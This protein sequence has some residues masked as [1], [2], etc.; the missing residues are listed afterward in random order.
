[1]IRNPSIDT[2]PPQKNNKEFGSTPVM[3]AS[4]TRLAEEANN[5]GELQLVTHLQET[6]SSSIDAP[7]VTDS[8][9]VEAGFRPLSTTETLFVGFTAFLLYQIRAK[10]RIGKRALKYVTKW[11]R[12]NLNS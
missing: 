6:D 3:Q 4:Y 9:P 12:F 5:G 1:M 10:A 2:S 7:Q 11:T 8:V